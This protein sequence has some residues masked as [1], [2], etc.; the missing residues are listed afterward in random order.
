MDSRVVLERDLES[1]GAA[2]T[3]LQAHIGTGYAAKRPSLD[4]SV[5]GQ[6]LVRF[7]SGNPSLDGHLSET[8]DRD[9]RRTDH[10]GSDHNPGREGI[11]LE[12]WTG[13]LSEPPSTSTIEKHEVRDRRRGRGDRD[14]RGGFVDTRVV[15]FATD[16]RSG[17]L[18]EV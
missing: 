11:R 10:E 9:D 13:L 8:P 16:L 3:E 14:F 17:A 15:S 12:L 1:F 18:A 2:L 6:A 7:V 4:T 5:P